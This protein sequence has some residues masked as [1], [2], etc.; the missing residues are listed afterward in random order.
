MA[1]RTATINADGIQ[2]REVLFVRYELNQQTDV[3]GQPTGTTRGGKIYIKVK[4]N[5]DGNTELLEWMIDT[6]MSKSGTIS[7][8]NRQGGEMKHLSFKEGYVVEYAETYDSTNSLLQ[9]EEFTISAKEIQVGNARHNNR[10]T[11]DN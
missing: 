10:W 4:S 8:P 5:D 7:F 9:Y 3:E 6:Y 11:I 1:T 2:E